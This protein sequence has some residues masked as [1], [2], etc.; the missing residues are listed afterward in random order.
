MLVDKWF[1]CGKVNEEAAEK[2]E[3]GGHTSIYLW[4]NEVYEV[5]RT[6]RDAVLVIHGYRFLIEIYVYVSYSLYMFW[7][8]RQL[9][10]LMIN[11]K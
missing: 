7:V 2:A 3:Y 10:Y 1:L 11:G 8:L 9:L 5:C 4:V 6:R